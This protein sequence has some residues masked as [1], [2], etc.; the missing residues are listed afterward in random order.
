MKLQLF[1][2]LSHTVKVLQEK[3]ICVVSHSNFVVIREKYTYNL[4]QSGHLN[5]SGVSGFK[6]IWDAVANILQI[7]PGATRISAVKID[8]I[9]ATSWI[10]H[11]IDLRKLLH[12][13]EPS[14]SCS[15]NTTL[16]PGLFAKTKCGTV[17]IF[18][19]G[20]LVIVGC[21]SIR[22]MSFTMGQVW[23]ALFSE[24]VIITDEQ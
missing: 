22:Q 11:Q 17:I 10:P 2:S 24:D 18:R 12:K 14:V 13:I 1:F 21:K 9:S 20:K 16:F 7:I 19:S 6:P 8:N 23:G 15:L 3:G 5:V 4:F